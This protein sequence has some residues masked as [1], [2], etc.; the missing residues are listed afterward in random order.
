VSV[1]SGHAFTPNLLSRAAGLHESHHR[2][3]DPHT[4]CL[5]IAT[6]FT[7]SSIHVQLDFMSPITAAKALIH[8]A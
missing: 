4:R 8:A 7:L 1:K 3:Q 5:R 2:R 6:A